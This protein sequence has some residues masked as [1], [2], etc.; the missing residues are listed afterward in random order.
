MSRAWSHWPTKWRMNSADRGSASI[1]ADLGREVGAELV[2]LGQPDQLVVGHRRPEEIGQPRGQGVFVDQRIPAR[3]S[4]ARPPPRGRGT[5]ARSGRPPSPGPRRTRKSVPAGPRPP[6]PGQRAGP[7]SRRP[8]GGGRPLRRNCPGARGHRA[9]VRRHPRGLPPGRSGRIRGGRTQ[10]RSSIGP[11]RV[12]DWM[13]I[14]SDRTCFSSGV[15]GWTSIV[16]SCGPA[17]QSRSNSKRNGLPS[18]RTNSRRTSSS[19]SARKRSRQRL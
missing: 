17:F 7:W 4:P 9:G 16:S 18:C 12:T 3:S 5:G 10:Y 15:S 2:L 14:D 11:R 19:P 6:R 1:R 8:R 13:R